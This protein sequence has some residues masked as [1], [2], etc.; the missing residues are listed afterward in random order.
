MDKKQITI[1]NIKR[2][3]R[4]V[5]NSKNYFKKLHLFLKKSA[6]GA[7]SVNFF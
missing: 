4:T 3:I 2:K 1:I 6:L 5:I 7:F